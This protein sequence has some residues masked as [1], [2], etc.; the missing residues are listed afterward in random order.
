MSPADC[1]LGRCA[2]CTPACTLICPHSGA[3]FAH[4]QEKALAMNDETTTM[5]HDKIQAELAK[6]IAQISKL[7]AE[8]SKINR[9]NVFYPVIVTATATLAIVAVVKIFL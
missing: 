4:H 5:T 1:A 2:R 3:A 8:T 7:T 6:L 9:E